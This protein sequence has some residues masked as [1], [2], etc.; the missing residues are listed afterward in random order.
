MIVFLIFILSFLCVA[1]Y[2][3]FTLTLG[4][5]ISFIP[6]LVYSVFVFFFYLRKEKGSKNFSDYEITLSASRKSFFLNFLVFVLL[7]LIYV[8][9]RK[10]FP[11]Y[12]T[13]NFAHFI[14]YV[15][16]IQ[17]T[18]IRSPGFMLMNIYPNNDSVKN[19]I[20]LFIN[21][22]LKYSIIIWALQPKDLY[23]SETGKIISY[24]NFTLYLINFYYKYFI[25]KN[26]FLFEKLL[27]IKY[28]QVSKNKE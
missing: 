28:Y 9:G 3:D 18:V 14:L 4:N 7:S 13:R 19:M 12:L 6:Y 20:M 27:G 2:C 25:S 26:Y 10:L 21:N 8:S 22:I 17:N 16:L 15:L 23:Y 1:P 5:Y 24:F 11:K